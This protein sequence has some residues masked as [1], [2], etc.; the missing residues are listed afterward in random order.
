M[1]T[2]RVVTIPTSES[3][4]TFLRKLRDQECQCDG[5]DWRLTLL[6][7]TIGCAYSDSP[8]TSITS[9]WWSSPT[10]SMILTGT[11][12]ATPLGSGVAALYLERDPTMTSAQVKKAMQ[13]DGSLGVVLDSGSFSPNILLSTVELG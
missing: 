6:T 9:A 3:A 2:I 10:D 11:S 4:L 8:G 12:M 5:G 1:L 13:D 7:H